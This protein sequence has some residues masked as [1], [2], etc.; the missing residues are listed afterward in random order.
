MIPDLFY[1]VSDEQTK[2]GGEEGSGAAGIEEG[3]LLEEYRRNK[4][5]N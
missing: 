2:P 1:K 5:E 4:E 3:E